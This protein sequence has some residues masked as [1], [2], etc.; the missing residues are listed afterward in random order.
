MH[1]N[2]FFRTDARTTL[3]EHFIAAGTVCSL[4][5]NS[6]SLLQAARETFV[7]VASPEDPTEISIRLWVEDADSPGQPWPKPYV[8]G[9]GHLV[10]AGFDARS[11]LLANL[12]TLRV[13]GRFSS[14]MA[15]N[16]TYWRTVIF[17]VLMS[18]VCGSV[19]VIEL[20]ASCVAKNGLGLILAGPSRSGKSTLALALAQQGFQLLSDDRTFCSLRRGELWAWGLPRPLKLRREA[21]SW[22]DE[23]RAQ[24]PNAIQNG[25]R[26]FH[27]EL[28]GRSVTHC[29]PRMFVFLERCDEHGISIAELEKGASKCRIEKELLPETSAA[30]QRQG[31]IV[32]ELLS[33]SP[34]LLRYGGTPKEIAS[35]LA[36]SFAN[37]QHC[38]VTGGQWRAS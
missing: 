23:L 15:A 3:C 6:E 20:H 2:D 30:M 14:A 21:A 17:P 19:G 11:S 12:H 33:L 7:A 4:S 13:I 34:Y 32:E 27:H 38:Q 35:Q 29:R 5:T 24:E 28:K 16:K 26:V 18:I 31:S 1:S 37:W 10:F 22:F 8:R 25:E 36:E 9:L